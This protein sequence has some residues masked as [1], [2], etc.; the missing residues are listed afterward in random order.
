MG[1]PLVHQALLLI[2]QLFLEFLLSDLLELHFPC[3]LS[4]DTLLFGL[5]AL[6]SCLLLMVVL[7]RKRVVLSFLAID[8]V[9][10]FTVFSELL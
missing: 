2:N 1:I 4:F 6:G 10:G 9:N 5:L 3:N 7:F 8:S